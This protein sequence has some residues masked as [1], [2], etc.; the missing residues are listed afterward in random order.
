MNIY[1]TPYWLLPSEHFFG[2]LR[3]VELRFNP[4]HSP[5]NGRFCSKDMLDAGG[6]TNSSESIDKSVESGIINSGYHSNGC[7]IE[8]K[9]AIGFY[10]KKGAKHS[11]EFFAVG[12]TEKDGLKLQ[13]DI[14]SQF[15]TTKAYDK[16]EQPNH[17]KTICINMQLG[18]NV[19]KPFKTV[20]EKK[21]SDTEW[22]NIT[23][24]DI[25]DHIKR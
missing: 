19:K 12:Y 11:H 22:R 15:D 5:I 17:T 24:F 18:V 7:F 16:R 6:G 8:D 14:A 20:W 21:P 2:E 23:A 10:L 4:Y 13:K 9:K 25:S 3:A 1:S